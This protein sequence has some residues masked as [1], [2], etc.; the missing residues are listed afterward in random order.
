MR[1]ALF[2]LALLWSS[3]AAAGDSTVTLLRAAFFVKDRPAVV[4]FYRD[5]LGYTEGA[6]TIGAGPYPDGNA[7]GLPA[8]AHI[9]L[10]YLKSDDG[11][12]V[13]VMSTDAQL[14]EVGRP[15]GTANAW[16]DVV[17]I[18]MVKNIDAIY[19]RA[20]AAGATVLQPPKL[21][22]SGRAK[23]MFLRDP[24]GIRLEFNEILS[25]GK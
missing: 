24:A 18:H 25:D 23:Q 21:A 4:A 13:A 14:P 6:T 17:L 12:F 20:V 19:A 22:A 10:T 1:A 9:D 2:G 8:G 3:A 5:V 15:T 11:A 7:W 16:N